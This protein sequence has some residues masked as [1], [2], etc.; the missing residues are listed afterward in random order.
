[1]RWSAERGT[2]MTRVLWLA[3]VVV[4]LGV[5]TAVAQERELSSPFFDC[6][7]INYFD[8]GCPE[9]EREAPQEQPEAERPAAEGEGGQESEWVE[10]N[11]EMLAPLFPRESLGRDAPELYRALLM[12]PTLENAR[13]FVR[14]YSRRM[15]RIA[16]VQKLIALAGGEFLA[17][18]AAE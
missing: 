18:G 8:S 2:A 12:Q 5:C 10:E 6:P 17:G 15:E 13:R 16:A 11:P 4:A 1:M 9:L 3:A 7:F 14:W